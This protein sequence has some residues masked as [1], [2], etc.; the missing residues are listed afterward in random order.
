M[1][2]VSKYFF[3]V[4]EQEPLTK[5]DHTPFE[6]EDYEKLEGILRDT[7]SILKDLK[8]EELFNSQT[9]FARTYP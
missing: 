2:F 3:Q 4:P 9:G 1:V 8:Q 7:A 5:S 6:P